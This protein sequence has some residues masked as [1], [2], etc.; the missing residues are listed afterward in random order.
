MRAARAGNIALVNEALA[1][2]ANVKYQG[3]VSQCTHTFTKVCSCSPDPR[4]RGNNNIHDNQ[5]IFS[6]ALTVVNIII[7]L[8]PGLR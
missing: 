1:K 6:T 3:R 2:G 8:L 5:C 4:K 7:I